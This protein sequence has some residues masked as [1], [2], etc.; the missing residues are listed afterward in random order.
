M[1]RL[2]TELRLAG[3][4]HLAQPDADGLRRSA[5]SQFLTDQE[6]GMAAVSDAL[7]AQYFRH[8]EHPH[9][10]IEHRL[11]GRRR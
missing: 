4:D 10:M 11:S 9:H 1:L 6:T 7:T 3:L 5:L 2:L 8:E